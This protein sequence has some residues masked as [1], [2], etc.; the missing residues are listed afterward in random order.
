LLIIQSIMFGDGVLLALG[1]NIFNMAFIWTFLVYYVYSYM[2]KRI[3]LNLSIFIS[4]LMS[5]I[6]AAFFCSV[7]LSLSG[8]ASFFKVLPAM[9]FPHFFIGLSEGIITLALINIIPKNVE[10]W[11]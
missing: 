11:K 4:S 6:L 3:G 1:A 2:A 9:F 7:E 8:T 5:V 10:I